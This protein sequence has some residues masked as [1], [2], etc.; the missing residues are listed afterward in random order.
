MQIINYLIVDD[1]P[2]ARKLLQTYMATLNNYHL[3]KECTNAIEAYEALHTLKID[4]IFL[5]IKMPLLSGTDFLR[6][7][8]NPPMV[9]FTTAYNK[10]AM[11]GYDLN[12]IDYLLKPISLPRLLSALEKVDGR[13]KSNIILNPQ[14]ASYIFIK[15]DNK[16]IKVSFEDILLIEGMQNYVKIHLAEKVIIATYTMKALETMLPGDKFLRVHR[17]FIVAINSI[18]AINGN[19]V[20][21]TYQNVPI[22]L[23]FKNA[24]LKYVNRSQ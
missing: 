1:E 11:E 14:Q 17:S 3:A 8:K 9:I 5:D 21:T 15:S 4:L 16:L 18:I 6:S 7:L 23:S 24:V 2:Q 22:G 20:E 10:Y 12:V 19:N 13:L